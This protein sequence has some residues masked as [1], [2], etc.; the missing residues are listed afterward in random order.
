M[1]IVM[2]MKKNSTMT[3]R[4]STGRSTWRPSRSWCLS[5]GGE[6]SELHQVAPVVVLNCHGTVIKV[7]VIELAEWE[8]G[9]TGMVLSVLEMG[10]KCRQ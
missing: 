2:I 7:V 4:T 1:T 9:S 3:T 6:Q 5:R 10:S 8:A